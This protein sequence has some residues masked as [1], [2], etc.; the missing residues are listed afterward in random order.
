MN[1]F[2]KYI[3]FLGLLSLCYQ[4]LANDITN[5]Y[6]PKPYVEIEHPQWSKNA[7]IYEVNVRQYTKEGTF[8]AFEKHLPRLKDLGVDIIWLMPIHPIGEKNRK[9]EKGSYYAVK[10]YK[11]VNPEFG[12]LEDLRALVK[13]AHSMDMY[14]ILDWVANHSAWDNS[15]TES[16]PEWYTKDHNGNFQP[17]PWWDWSDIIDFDY[18]N[19]YM[20]KYMTEALKYWVVEADIDGYRADVAGFIPTD[21]WDNVRKELDS[22]KPVFM[23]AEWD[24]K[25]LHKNAF[26]M[27]YAWALHDTLVKVNES[28][29]DASNVYLHF[30]HSLSAWPDNAIKMNFVD[31]HDKN[32]WEKTMFER[33]GPYLNASIVLTATAEGM[34]LLYSGQE[35]GLDRSL[36]FFDKDEIEWKDHPVGDLYKQLFALKHNNKALWNGKWGGKMIPVPNNNSKAIFS[37]ARQQAEDKVFVVINFSE[38]PQKVKFNENIQLGKYTEYFTTKEVTISANS[39]VNLPAYGYKIFVKTK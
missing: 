35:A 29:A 20:R 13:K 15:L 34:P 5:A 23:L 32:S 10:D 21:F 36:S 7:T 4:T 28:H 25:D 37:F 30:A 6:Q 16:N 26:D 12:N 39:Q 8:K 2:F 31:N 17:T 11:A 33:F 22:I 24:A 14:V 1:T 27:T 3:I 38:Q 18:N 19:P 9:G